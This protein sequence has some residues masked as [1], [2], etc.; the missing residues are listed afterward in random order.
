[1][2]QLNP[3]VINDGA[4]TP[5]AHTFSPSTRNGQVAKLHEAV[6]GGSLAARPE[7]TLTG[8]SLGENGRTTE[9]K[10]LVLLVPN[11]VVETI[12]GVPVTKVLGYDKFVISHISSKFSTEQS[13]KNL[14]VMGLNLLNNAAIAAWIDKAEGLTG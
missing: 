14:R 12:N 9:L 13:R 11:T 10:D 6:V 2:P 4:T 5:V 8:K 3:I 7:L 1:M